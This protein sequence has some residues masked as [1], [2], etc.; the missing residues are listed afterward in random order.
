MVIQHNLMAMNSM[1]SL[2]I[3]VNNQSKKTEKLSSGYRINRAADD[4]AGLAIS[5]KMR[6]MIRGLSQGTENTQDGI[7]YVQIGDGAMGEIHDMLH[8]MEELAVKGANGTLM[9]DDRGMIDKEVQQLKQQ[10]NEISK[11]TVFNE[12]QIFD[13]K[14][15]LIV[16]GTPND[17]SFFDASYDSTTGKYAYGGFLFQGQRVKWEDVDPDMVDPATGL[18][19]GG[20]YQYSV[21]GTTYNFHTK[22]DG[23]VPSDITRTMSVAVSNDGVT[24]DGNKIGLDKLVDESGNAASENN[25]HSGAWMV[26]YRGAE[27]TF[28]VKDDVKSLDELTEKLNAIT[29]ETQSVHYVWEERQVG[30]VEKQAVSVNKV[31]NVRVSQTMADALAVNPV[32]GFYVHADEEGIFVSDLNDNEIAGSKK[33]W[34][35]MQIGSWD[36]GSDISGNKTYRYSYGDALGELFSFSFQLGDETSVDSVIDGLDGMKIDCSDFQSGYT[37]SVSKSLADVQMTA[38]ARLNVNFNEEYALGRDF[39]QKN[40]QL[41]DEKLSYN[42]GAKTAALA[43]QNGGSTVISLTGSTSSAESALQSKMDN[44][45]SLVADMMKKSAI[46]GVPYVPQTLTDVVGAS[47]ITTS[48]YFS[49][50]FTLTSDMEMTTGG[51][52]IVGKVHPT[53]SIDF[54]NLTTADDIKALAGTGFD[55]TCKTCSEHYS[56]MFSD[57]LS[58]YDTTPEGYRYKI[59]TN[60]LNKKLEIDLG[61]LTANGVDNGEKLAQAFVKIASGRFDKHYTQYA[62]KDTKLYIYDNRAQSTPAP[63][64]D[65]WTAPYEADNIVHM[66]VRLSD[67]SGDGGFVNLNYTYDLTNV[68]DKVGVKETADAAGNYVK[69]SELM[70]DPSAKGYS[71]YNA[72][73][74]GSLGLTRY[75]IES[76]FKDAN[77][78]ETT[79]ADAV[80]SNAKNLMKDII[81]DTQVKLTSNQYTTLRTKAKELPN[82]EMA[83]VFD[84]DVRLVGEAEKLF[85]VHSGVK[86]DQTYIPRFSMNAAAMGLSRANTRTGKDAQK[87]IDY[88]KG[89][90]QYVSEKRAIYGAVQNRLEHTVKNNQNKEE[91]MTAAESRIRDTDVAHTMVGYANNQILLQAGQSILAQANQSKQGI[92]S[93]L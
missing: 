20:A 92:L 57:S 66:N 26:D 24:I 29:D 55:S 21:G 35:A 39:D 46:L 4:A 75:K 56:V 25:F 90:N 5:E 27:I 34:D 9:D 82:V 38:S 63:E 89:A 88:V 71:V 69:N 84:S 73:T 68:A 70:N 80:A 62:A 51:P 22:K 42:A 91:N 8:R 76:V 81:E 15:S 93:L 67:D 43:L 79:K 61:S 23:T 85:I 16:S 28:F 11:H 47:N 74:M 45:Y 32:T 33:K 50:N 18:F 65:F 78:V 86:G 1:R 37:T 54:Q 30:D 10:I 13:N 59:S 53:A 87:M 19:T 72:A 36:S 40:V 48:G 2:G 31:G 14:S 7:S 64:A 17:M 41:A 60:G 6:W 49:E 58:S 12:L 77:G 52:G 44:Y 83:P 3:V